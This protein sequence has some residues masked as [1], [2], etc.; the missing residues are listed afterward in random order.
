MIPLPTDPLQSIQFWES[1]RLPNQPGGNVPIQVPHRSNAKIAPCSVSPISMHRSLLLLVTAIVIAI[2]QL[3]YGRQ[4]LY[5]MSLLATF[6]HE[7]GHGLA[8]LL[9][10]AEFDALLLNADGSGMAVWRGNPGRVATA[11]IAA[12]GLLGP[13]VAGITLLLLSRAA[14]MARA[15]LVLLACL[16]AMAVLAW[17]RNPFGVSFLL[18]IATLLTL[19]AWSMSDNAARFLLQF[20]A[21]TLCLSWFSDLD[22][23]FSSH[24]MVN[25][26]LHVSDSAVM[27]D[28]LWLPYW[29]WGALVAFVSLCVAA[30]GITFASR[31]RPGT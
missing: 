15:A 11:L 23:M 21:V 12:G 1:P 13:T 22:Y 27:A 24:A 16:I 20:V 2:W 18:A 6:A 25:G 5:P 3:P 17:V 29:V 4:I 14:R 19:A 8:A 10:G 26:T 9:A 28:A 30:L 7:M 31:A